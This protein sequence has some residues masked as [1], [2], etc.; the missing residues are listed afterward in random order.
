MGNIIVA[1]VLVII[2]LLAL[3]SAIKHFKG[4]SGC[5]GDCCGGCCDSESGK[6]CLK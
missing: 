6:R 1:V 3:R 4:Q 2:A 5:C